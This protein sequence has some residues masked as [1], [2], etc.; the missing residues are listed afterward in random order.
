MRTVARERER[1]AA[2]AERGRQDVARQLSSE[3]CGARIVARLRELSRLHAPNAPAPP[4]AD[5]AV[6]GA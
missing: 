2:V 5:L 6:S 1:V 3:A 4:A